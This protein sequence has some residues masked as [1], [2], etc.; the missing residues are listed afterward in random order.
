V[1]E[2]RL[3]LWLCGFFC[4][5]GCTFL[6]EGYEK[7]TVTPLDREDD[8][9]QT[10][11]VEGVCDCSDEQKRCEKDFVYLWGTSLEM[12]E[13]I[14]EDCS[15]SSQVVGIRFPGVNIQKDSDIHSA[16][17]Q[18]TA[19]EDNYKTTNLE[20]V[21]QDTSDPA[22]FDEEESKDITQRVVC[23]TNVIWEVDQWVQKCDKKAAQQTPDLK[24]L[25]Q[26]IVSLPDW[27]NGNPIAFIIKGSGKRVAFA[28]DCTVSVSY[29]CEEEAACLH[30][31]APELIIE[32]SPP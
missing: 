3:W 4:L 6:V 8:A 10:L 22:R 25:V 27:K 11:N 23:S 19:A 18:F 14:I 16:Y 5:S 26:H 24:E 32:Y 17:I 13:S 2:I 7:I 15:I 31:L 9:E 1:N 29:D 28:F 12:T 20:I 21:V 30:D